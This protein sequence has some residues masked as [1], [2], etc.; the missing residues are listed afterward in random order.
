MSG[1]GGGAL[2]KVSKKVEGTIFAESNF[3]FLT[4]DADMASMKIAIF[5]TDGKTYASEVITK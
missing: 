5:D 3:G 4:L 1:G 2:S